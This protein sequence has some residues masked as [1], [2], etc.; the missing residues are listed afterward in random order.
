M[1][2][3]IVLLLVGILL[4]SGCNN[5]SDKGVQ[6]IADMDK[7]VENKLN[8]MT[9]DEKIGQMMIIYY[10]KGNVDTTLKS[11][12]STVKPGGM[13]LFSENFTTYDNTINFIKEVKSSSSIPMFIAIDEEGGRVQRLTSIK[14]TKVSYVPAMYYLGEMDDIDLTKDTGKV[15][16][17]ELKVFGINMD[18]APVID[19]YENP[20]NEVIGKRSFGTNYEIVSKHG[21]AM[22]NSLRDNNIIPVY[23]HFP[24]HGNTSTDSH[25]DLPIVTKT[26]EELLKDE[27]IPFKKAIEND[28]EM[29]MIGHLAVPEITGDNTPAS[30]SKE[31]ITDLLKNEMGYKGL[32]ITDALNMGAITK[33]YSEQEIY[34]MAINAGVDILLM[35][36]NSKNALQYIKDSVNKGTI[37]EERINESVRKIL[38]LKYERID[39]DYEVYYDKSY[40]N[41]KEHQDILN[42]IKIE[43]N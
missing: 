5:N 25:V 21:I 41:S 36:V 35:P 23:K 14:D 10:L 34:E 26:K 4:L 30:L 32:V 39:N 24:G 37:S 6:G 15:I 17:E 40:L 19:I 1:K 38:K 3:I 27:L 11:S 2:K 8:S 16:A 28:A 13:I 42:K 43:E 20:D 9:I 7:I 31:I 22:G 18:F 29:I 12:L 33:N